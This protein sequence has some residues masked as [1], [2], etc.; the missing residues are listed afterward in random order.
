MSYLLIYLHHFFPHSIHI[1][2]QSH[3][4]TKV[5]IVAL[6]QKLIL[7]SVNIEFELTIMC[8]IVA[9]HLSKQVLQNLTL[10]NEVVAIVISLVV[11]LPAIISVGLRCRMR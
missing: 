11:L 7:D 6:L 10:S 9:V 2:Y 3:K 4:Q 8:C 5:D 1:H